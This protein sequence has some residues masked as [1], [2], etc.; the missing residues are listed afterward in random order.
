MNAE[1]NIAT[2]M[3]RV[4]SVIVM[5]S[6]PIIPCADYDIDSDVQLSYADNVVQDIAEDMALSILESA[7]AIH[8]HYDEELD[9]HLDDAMSVNDKEK[10]QRFNPDIAGHLIKEMKEVLMFSTTYLRS[11]D[12]RKKTGVIEV[13]YIRCPFNH[14]E[15]KVEAMIIDGFTVEVKLPYYGETFGIENKICSPTAARYLHRQWLRKIPLHVRTV[16][17]IIEKANSMSLPAN[18]QGIE[19]MTNREK[20][21]T[22]DIRVNTSEPGT[23]FWYRYLGLHR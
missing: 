16:V 10:K 20:N 9:A 12:R 1:E 21:L 11:K 6:I 15:G 7:R 3:A 14:D 17:S 18:N 2:A 19:G 23:Y 22:R 8:I 13:V 4:A 5:F